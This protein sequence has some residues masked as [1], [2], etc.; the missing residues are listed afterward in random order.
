MG[1]AFRPK[2]ATVEVDRAETPACI[3]R[4]RLVAGTDFDR[5]AVYRQR[6]RGV[7]A[8]AHVDIVWNT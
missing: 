1:N 7:V 2:D 4:K 5:S 6:S 8:V 3:S